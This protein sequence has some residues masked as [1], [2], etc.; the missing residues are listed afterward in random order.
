MP[1][2]VYLVSGDTGEE[3]RTICACASKEDARRI[4]ARL[5]SANPDA[6]ECYL[7]DGL[8]V[9]TDAALGDL[10]SIEQRWAEAVNLGPDYRYVCSD[11][12]VVG[13]SWAYAPSKEQCESIAKDKWP[14]MLSAR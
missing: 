12:P 11:G 13:E 8:P 1:D 3:F 6:Y 9:V 5:E 4:I 2:R 14:E 7:I 10:W